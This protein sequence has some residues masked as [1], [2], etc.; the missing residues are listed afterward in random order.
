MSKKHV[1]GSEVRVAAIIPAYNEA[2]TIAA[3]VEEVRKASYIAEV[4]VV[5]DGSTDETVACARRAGARVVEL[6]PNRGKGEAL[7]QGVAASS[8]THLFFCDADLLGLTKEHVDAL[9]LPVISDACGMHVG[10]RDR[11]MVANLLVPFLPLISGERVLR[12]EIFEA[13]TPEVSHGYM[14]EVGL[15]RAAS[16]QRV[17]VRA[18]RMKGV[19]IRKK[20]EKVGVWKGMWGYCVMWKQVLQAY[21]RSYRYIRRTSF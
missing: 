2:A 1:L 8:A 12:R 20:M 13:L 7:A 16:V 21:G 6:M 5:S 9:I 14:I 10:L 3:V 17:A 18:S 19:S 11:G 4:I 15:N